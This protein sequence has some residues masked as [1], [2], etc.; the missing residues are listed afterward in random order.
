MP[1]CFQRARAGDRLVDAG[2]N[3]E[4]LAKQLDGA[5]QRLTDDPIAGSRHEAL[6]RIKRC[7]PRSFPKAHHTAGQHQAERRCVDEKA[8][9]MTQMPRPLS[10]TDL[11]GNEPVCGLRVRNAQ[12]GLGKAHQDDAFLARQAILAHERIKTAATYFRAAHATDELARHLLGSAR[13]IVRPGGPL[14]QRPDKACL[15]EQMV[16]RNLIAR[17]YWRAASRPLGSLRRLPCRIEHRHAALPRVRSPM[18]R[19]MTW[20]KRDGP[21]SALLPP[22]RLSPFPPPADSDKPAA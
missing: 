18:R 7:P 6:D 19:L 3:H 1:R 13:F 14:D 22:R 17:R 2:P 10:I 15:I 16:G 4:L 20:D 5:P 9:R 21:P 11:I 8:A 12:Q